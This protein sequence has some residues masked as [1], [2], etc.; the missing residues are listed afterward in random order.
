[1]AVE[2]NPQLSAAEESEIIEQVF[3]YILDVDQLAMEELPIHFVVMF[4]DLAKLNN[5]TIY[6]ALLLF[7]FGLQPSELSTQYW[8]TIR[9]GNLTLSDNFDPEVVSSFVIFRFI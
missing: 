3:K 5:L 1:M 4:N 7:K 9:S 2:E 8:Q 6:Q